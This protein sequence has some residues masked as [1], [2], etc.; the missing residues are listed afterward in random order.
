[1][2][3]D[4]ELKERI[5]AG[6]YARWAADGLLDISRG[7]PVVATPEPVELERRQATHGYTKEDL[8]MVLKPMAGDAHEPVFSMGDDSPLP[9]MA[10][11]P[12]PL[13]HYLR[14]RFAQVTNPPSTTCGS[15]G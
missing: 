6:S 2:Q 9:Q 15:A 7:E 14:Q 3:L 1:V 10:G 4:A 13:H 12:R 11:R 8:A 5:S